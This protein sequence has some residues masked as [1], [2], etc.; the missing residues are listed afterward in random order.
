MKLVVQAIAAVI[1]AAAFGS[2]CAQ[3]Y[4]VKPVRL[5]VPYP[6]GG[7]TDIFARMLGA[8]LGEVLGQQMVIENRAGAAGVLGA[9][10]AAK[11]PPDGYTLVVGQASNLA[12]N[13]HMMSK[14]PY[15]PVKDFAP[16]TLIATSPSLLV[17]HPSLPVRSIKDLVALAGRARSTMRR[18]ATG[19]RAIW[20]RSISRRSR[21]PTSFTYLI[22][23]RRL[24]CST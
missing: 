23:A 14:L 8:K 10:A 2:V 6:P 16:I 22:K 5:I 12:I 20:R 15:D 1:V 9:E 4:P 18:P 19:A 3:S 11:A 7:G 21:K 13:P 24:R 17:V